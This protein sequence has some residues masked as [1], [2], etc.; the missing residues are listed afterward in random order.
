[1]SFQ[2]DVC[3]LDKRIHMLD[4]IVNDMVLLI[5]KDIAY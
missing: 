4:R 5:V 1:M 2:V 3:D